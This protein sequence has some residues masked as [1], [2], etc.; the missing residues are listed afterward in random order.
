MLIELMAMPNV[1]LELRLRVFNVLVSGSELLR[2]RDAAGWRVFIYGLF[3][4]GA[5]WNM[6][7]YYVDESFPK[8]LY[9]TFPPVINHVIKCIEIYENNTR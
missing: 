2:A 6:E 1:V 5:R 3:L 7:D 4:E 9:D 8:V